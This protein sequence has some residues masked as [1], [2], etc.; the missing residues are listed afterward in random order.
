ME[1]SVLFSRLKLLVFEVE[2]RQYSSP[3]ATDTKAWGGVKLCERNPKSQ[4]SS[5]SLAVGEQSGSRG[6]IIRRL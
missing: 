4:G 5:S 3:T 2:I 6:N 1:F